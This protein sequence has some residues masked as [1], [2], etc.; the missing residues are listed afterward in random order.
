[1]IDKFRGLLDF[2]GT[3]MEGVGLD[4]W[5]WL[6]YVSAV[7]VGSGA[8][9]FWAVAGIYS[10]Q[11]QTKTGAKD[12]E[13]PLWVYAGFIIAPALGVAGLVLVR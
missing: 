11:L 2:G 6:Q 3:L 9:I 12:D 10:Y 5:L 1:M 7:I 8:A 13:L 4:I